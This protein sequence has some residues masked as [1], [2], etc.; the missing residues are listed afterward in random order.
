MRIVKYG[1]IKPKEV[2]C[3]HCGTVLEYIPN[4][5][6]HWTDDWYYIVCPVCK[7]TIL[8]DNNG[9]HLERW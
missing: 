8:R 7:G 5:I 3:N 2:K 9:N 6:R 4:N 1:C